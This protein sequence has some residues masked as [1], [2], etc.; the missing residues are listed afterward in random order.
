VLLLSPPAELRRARHRR[1]G[2]VRV[3]IRRGTIELKAR[4]NSA[5]A[6]GQEFIPFC[7]AEAVANVPQLDPFGKIP[8][9]TFCAAKVKS[10]AIPAVAE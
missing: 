9:Y 7:Y 10:V 3:T 8:E 5:V 6:P 1:R 2:R 4:A